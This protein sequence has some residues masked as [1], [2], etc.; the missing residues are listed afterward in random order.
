MRKKEEAEEAYEP[1][2]E[3]EDR[4]LRKKGKPVEV[5]PTPG[6]AKLSLFTLR[7]DNA[8]IQALIEMGEREGVGASVVARGILQRGVREMGAEIPWEMEMQ[9]CLS[10]ALAIWQRKIGGSRTGAVHP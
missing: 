8:T 10:E 4:K 9:R 7:L 3:E 1:I 6:D 5:A 2:T